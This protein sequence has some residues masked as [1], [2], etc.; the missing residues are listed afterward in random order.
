ML[1]D[2]SLFSLLLD[3]EDI[4]LESLALVGVFLASAWLAME[5]NEC[6]FGLVRGDGREMRVR[7]N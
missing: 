6:A 4:D 1:S 2:T 3:L 7:R 5:E